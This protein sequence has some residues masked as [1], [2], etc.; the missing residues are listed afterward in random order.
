[1]CQCDRKTR[2]GLHFPQSCVIIQTES[3]NQEGGKT[4]WKVAAEVERPVVRELVGLMELRNAHPAFDVEGDIEVAAGADGAFV[5]RDPNSILR[6]NR[7][8]TFEELEP[9]MKNIWAIGA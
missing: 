5:I 1:M 7:T 2:F 6:S 4:V 9:Q 8:W 3:Y